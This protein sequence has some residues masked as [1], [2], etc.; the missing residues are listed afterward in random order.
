MM[1]HV[2]LGCCCILALLTSCETDNPV[3]EAQEATH[4]NFRTCDHDKH[5]AELMQNEAYRLAQ[6]AKQQRLE[7]AQAQRQ[8]NCSTPTKIPVAVHYQGITNINVSCLR[9]LAQNQIDVLNAD[10]GGTNSD[11]SIW[12]NFAS[13]WPGIENGEGCIQFVLAN[14][15]HPSGFDITDGDP[16]VTINKTSGSSNSK[17]RNY[18]NIYVRQGISSLGYS[19]LGGDGD[20]DGVVVSSRAFGT[21]SG[22]AGVVPQ[23]PYNKGRTLTHELGHYLYL[24]HIWGSGCSTD[25]GVADTP[26]QEKENYGCPGIGYSSCGSADLHL[27]YMDYTNDACMLMFTKGQTARMESYIASS[28]QGVVAN[29]SNVISGATNPTPTCN[30]GIQNG[31]ETGVDC[32][33][34]CEDCPPVPTCDDGIQ[35][36][37]ETGVDCGGSCAACPTCNDG[38]KNG[39]ETGVDCGGSCT[40]C[41]VTPTCNDGIQNGNETGVD[42]GGNCAPCEA[43]PTCNDGIQ[44]GNET[45][46]DCGGNCAPCQQTGNPNPPSSACPR[47]TNRYASFA[48]NN[49]DEIRTIAKMINRSNNPEA[50]QMVSKLVI[51]QEAVLDLME[52]LESNTRAQYLMTSIVETYNAEGNNFRVAGNVETSI[53]EYL[54]IAKANTND[55][56]LKQLIEEAKSIINNKQGATLDELF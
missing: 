49:V 29:A 38:V 39:N 42:C 50:R 41:A 47:M 54:N 30:D 18:I 24:K 35:N 1:K 34:S 37:S 20:G 13:T 12:N 31:N 55:T 5:V 8:N 32:G 16:A 7:L 52:T 46:V 22:C 19:P 15:N 33:G 10:Y 44:N 28:L 26:E 36:G 14:K 25:D 4:E 17:W 3:F 6:E 11:I 21:G 23:S 48:S 40:P 43:V 45:G 9:Q 2:F 53:A 56:N 27:N 51:N